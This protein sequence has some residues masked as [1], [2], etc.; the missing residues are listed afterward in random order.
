[1]KT[2]FFLRLLLSSFLLQ[3]FYSDLAATCINDSTTQIK[4]NKFIALDYQAGRVLPSNDFVRGENQ[5]GE[6]IDYFEASRLEFGWQTMGTRLWEQYYNL[7]YFGIGIYGVDFFDDNEL[8]TPSAIYGY[9][10]GPIKRWGKLSLNYQMGFGITYNWKHYDQEINP[11]NIAIGANKTVYIDIGANLNYYL[12][13]RFDIGFGFSASH[14]SN[15]ATTLPNFGLNLAAARIFAKYQFNKERPE[16]KKWDIPEYLKETEFYAFVAIGSK[17]AEFDTTNTELKDKYQ[18]VN[19]F[20]MT[21][22]TALQRQV[23]Y[24]FKFGG[25]LDLS[26]DESTGAQMVILDP[27]TKKVDAPFSDKIGIGIFVAGEWVFGNLSVIGQPGYY[28]KK[29]YGD[30]FYQRLGIKYHFGKYIF[31]GINIRAVQFTKADLIEW[32]L[33]YHIKW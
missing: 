3:L 24:K 14:F 17:Q 32:N 16:I 18:D 25:G 28:L 4:R 27:T 26:Y 31:A 10:G 23:S 22:S 21:I 30:K 29:T 33:G 5:S 15:G 9:W 11:F 13:N 19:F 6:P 1:M 12:S 20:A 8:G 7:P 2:P